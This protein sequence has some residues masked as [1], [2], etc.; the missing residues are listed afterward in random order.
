MTMTRVLTG[1]NGCHCVKSYNNTN[2]MTTK[3]HNVFQ[4]WAEWEKFAYDYAFWQ[5]NYM[6][7]VS[8]LPVAS[9][10][11]RPMEACNVH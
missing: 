5:W 6:G 2:V 4:T 1:Q 8:R 3:F 10:R 11:H 9:P 7:V